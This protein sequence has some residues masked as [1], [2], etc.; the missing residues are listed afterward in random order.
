VYDGTILAVQDA[1]EV[2]YNMHLKTEGI[3]ISDKT[4]RINVHSCLAVTCDGLVWVL[5][6]RGTTGKKPKT[7]QRAMRT[8]RYDR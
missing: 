7:N 8:R 5:D 1:T 2:N 6:Q 3:N 4:Q